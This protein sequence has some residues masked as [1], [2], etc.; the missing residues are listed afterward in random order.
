MLERSQITLVNT[1][2]LGVL[3]L[4]FLPVFIPSY[5]IEGESL[6][7]TLSMLVLGLATTI[8]GHIH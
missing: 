1:V 4:V 7:V 8:E 6:A 5:G 2:G 3:N